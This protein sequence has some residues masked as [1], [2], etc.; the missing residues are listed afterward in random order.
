MGIFLI[1]VTFLLFM[2]HKRFRPHEADLK[3]VMADTIREAPARLVRTV[4]SLW[5]RENLPRDNEPNP[6]S[7][8]ESQASAP[9][10]DVEMVIRSDDKEYVY[11]DE[12]NNNNRD[13]ISPEE[14]EEDDDDYEEEDDDKHKHH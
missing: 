6:P 11:Y 2:G 13:T 14:E 7:Y 10:Q 5:N 4:S 9:P 12:R 1:V 3:E 8:Y